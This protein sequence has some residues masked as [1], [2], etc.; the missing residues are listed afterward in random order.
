MFK[1]GEVRHNNGTK[2]KKLDKARA[3]TITRSALV[4]FSPI[5]FVRCCAFK[6]NNETNKTSPQLNFSGRVNSSEK[7]PQASHGRLDFVGAFKTST[8]QKKK[9]IQHAAPLS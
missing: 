6:I 4:L 3:L 5:A 2:V 8:R 7:R 9:N 1:V